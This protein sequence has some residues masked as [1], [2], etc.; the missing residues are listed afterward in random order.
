[1]GN[2]IINYEYVQGQD[3]ALEINFACGAGNRIR[4][5]IHTH[6]DNGLPIFSGTDIRVIYNAYRNLCINGLEFVTIGLVTSTGTYL[7]VVNDPLAFINFG[8]NYLRNEV[9]FELFE[10]L[11]SAYLDSNPGNPEKAFLELLNQLN[12]GLM[13]F[14][15]NLNDFSQWA[16]RTLNNSGTP[17]NT[18]CN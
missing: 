16:A 13:L 7:L 6:P 15:G 1:M 2:G 10:I 8:A 5:I 12:T 3:G 11:Y 9:D 4:G 17:V 14:K 18:T